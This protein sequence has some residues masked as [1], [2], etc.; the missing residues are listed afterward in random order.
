MQLR[1]NHYLP[2]SRLYLFLGAIL[3]AYSPASNATDGDIFP[4][5]TKYNAATY[6]SHPS[7]FKV[8]LANRCKEKGLYS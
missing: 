4:R 7:Y 2:L 5:G 3:A 6:H 1:Q 8:P